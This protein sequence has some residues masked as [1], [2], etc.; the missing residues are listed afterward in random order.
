MT[1]YNTGNPIGSTDARDRL[2][3]SENMD[4][5]ENSTTK[6]TH[7][8]RLGTLR[9]TR[10][11][12]EVQHD[13]QISAHK[14]EHDNQ[15]AAH[16]VEHDAQMQ[17]FES[18]FDGRLAG[19][20]FTRVGSFTS[21]AT[22]TDMR[23]VLIW[24]VSQGGDGHEY[25]WTGSFPKVVA[26][27]TTPE[28]SG[29]IGAGVWV[30]RTD[31]TLRDELINSKSVMV[32]VAYYGALGDGVT[33]DSDSN[34]LPYNYGKSFGGGVV[35]F[36]KTSAFYRITRRLGTYPSDLVD[37]ADNVYFEGES[38]S[39][40]KL[41]S[42]TS[43]CA[44][45]LEGNNVGVI[46]LNVDSTRSVYYDQD[47]TLQRDIYQTGIVV[48]GKGYTQSPR[49]DG[50]L[51]MFK[52]KAIVFGCVV[53][54]FSSP[55]VG[56]RSERLTI[57]ENITDQSTDTAILIDDCTNDVVVSRNLSTRS[58]D[59]NCCVRHYSNSPW[60]I[61]QKYIGRF[62]VIDNTFRLTF[63]KNLGVG[64]VSDIYVRGNTF[65][66]SW[67]GSMNLECDDWAQ[68]SSDYNKRVFIESNTFL[69]SGRNYNASEPLAI[70]RVA[71][72]DLDQCAAFHT[73]YRNSRNGNYFRNVVFT[74]NTIINP[75]AY[76]VSCN[77]IDA[78]TIDNNTFIAGNYNHG[79]GNIGTSGAA[80]KAQNGDNIVAANNRILG[81]NINFQYCY[82]LIGAKLLNNV[83]IANNHEQYGISVM[84]ADTQ[85]KASGVVYISQQ[86]GSIK[87]EHRSDGNDD[88]FSYIGTGKGCNIHVYHAE[89]WPTRI[90]NGSGTGLVL[91]VDSA[92]TNI[93]NVGIGV[94]CSPSR[95]LHITGPSGGVP[96]IRV[97]NSNV[98]NGS[99][100]TS[101]GSVGPLGAST[102]VQGW[103]QIDIGGVTRYMPFW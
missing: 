97:D 36:P 77:A 92:G 70:H 18:D 6:L 101:L 83:R 11:G 93:D 73:K 85:A 14:V 8:D 51:T 100:E 71:Y 26:A 46:N 53:T 30:D 78:V 35:F 27:G 99:V 86:A 65:D 3:N 91:G 55:I 4:I 57:A 25:G 16:E 72:P 81:D 98:N 21:G 90:Y 75:R 68:N 54:N 39:T 96:A 48:G 45:C 64:G 24:E 38:G 37:Y 33:D 61:A 7:P 22:L 41:D 58:G 88:R 50:D 34:D 2:D 74:G 17:V 19:M 79:S 67:A 80:I 94:G 69:N 31:V 103:L 29:G 1:T 20:A 28:T 62:K 56:F 42:G 52:S 102:T 47:L 9:K 5:L 76:G 60:A 32:S 15:I 82:E 87:G 66:M 10:Y 59:D 49:S 43:G 63:G 84:L 44:I 40:V 12:M 23:Q 13:N 89:N 95:R